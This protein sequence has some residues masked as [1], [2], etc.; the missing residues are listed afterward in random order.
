MDLAAMFSGIAVGISQQFGGPY[1]PGAVLDVTGA[2][3]DNGGSIATPGTLTSRACQVQIDV[4]TES[5]RQSEGYA[6]GDARFLILA[7]T[8]TGSLDTDARVEVLA[9]PNA[10]VWLVSAIERDALGIYY[11]GRGRRG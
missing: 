2:V 10:G 3:M 4:A 5:M 8:L 9:G 11:A 1:V 6:D 7:S